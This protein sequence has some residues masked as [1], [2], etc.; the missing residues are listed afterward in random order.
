MIALQ[1]VGAFGSVAAAGGALEV[2]VA[3]VLLD[4]EAV[5]AAGRMHTR[6]GATAIGSRDAVVV[7]IAQD[8][9]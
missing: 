4:F 8:F 6:V 1:K 5:E 7:L 9:R 2:V 3:V